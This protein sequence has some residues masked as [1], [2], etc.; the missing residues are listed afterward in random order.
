MAKSS[1]DIRTSDPKTSSAVKS[2]AETLGL[3]ESETLTLLVNL[4]AESVAK[5]IGANAFVTPPNGI[6]GV[7]SN[8]KPSSKKLLGHELTHT[9]QQRSAGKS[10]ADLELAASKANFYERKNNTSSDGS[11]H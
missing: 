10:V 9:M 7:G 1:S 5:N 11:N 3:S 4:G 2:M 8:A 6:M